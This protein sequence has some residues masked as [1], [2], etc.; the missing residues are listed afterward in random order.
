MALVTISIAL[1]ESYVAPVFLG[2]FVVQSRFGVFVPLA[3]I[4][5]RDTRTEFGRQ[6]HWLAH[7]YASSYGELNVKV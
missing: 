5:K 3:D 4:N 1:S 6:F 7:C 2:H